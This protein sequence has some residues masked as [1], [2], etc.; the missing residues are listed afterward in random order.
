MTMGR[1]R[2]DDLHKEW[3]AK[4]PAYRREYAALEEEFQLTKAV[5]EAR[6]RAVLTQEEVAKRMQTT[7]AVIVR[8]EGGGKPSLHAN[9]GTLCQ[10]NRK[11]VAHHLRA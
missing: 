4:K 8:L 6:S 1:I 9:A 5:I 3:M 7:Q 11:P 10:G 2:D